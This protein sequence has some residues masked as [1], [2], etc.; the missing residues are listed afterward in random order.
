MEST[1]VYVPIIIEY[2]RNKYEYL[3][4]NIGV[5]RDKVQAMHALVRAL[6]DG[7]W[8]MTDYIFECDDSGTNNATFKDEVL[9]EGD[10]PG[11]ILKVCKH[12]NTEDDLSE[13]CK[14]IVD[15]AYPDSWEYRID[16][17]ELQG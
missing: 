1:K 7:G 3:A 17:F 2:G 13:F 16:E 6:V 9:V 11:N 15:S 4:K 14:S 5:F 12:I 8:L 10:T